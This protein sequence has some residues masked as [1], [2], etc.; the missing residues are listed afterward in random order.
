MFAAGPSGRPDTESQHLPG[1]T[2]VAG[3]PMFAAG[4]VASAE[5]TAGP[6][7]SPEEFNERL[8]QAEAL[9]QKSQFEESQAIY[10]SLVRQP[11]DDAPLATAL[12]ETGW[13]WSLIL[14]DRAEEALAH[15]HRA[16][17]LDPLSAGTM[18]VLA[19]AYLETGDGERALGMALNA[20]QLAPESAEAHA[21]LAEAYLTN[22][23]KQEA[24]KAADK[25]LA[26]DVKSAEA[27]RV[28]G[29]LYVQVDGAPERALGELQI[30]A[31]LQPAL[32][33]RQYEL[34]LIL[35]RVKE[36]G[37]AITVLT[38]ALALYSHGSI[39]AAV[40]EAYYRLDEI[41]RARSYLLQALSNGA[42]DANTYGLLSLTFARQGRC[43]DAK[44]YFDQALAQDAADRPALQARSLCQ[45]TVR[46]SNPAPTELPTAQPTLRGQIAFP[47]WNTKTRQ[48]DVYVVDLGGNATSGGGTMSGGTNRSL[49][50][51]GVHQPAFSPDGR[52]L[53]VN[54]ERPGYMNLSLVRRDGSD[55]QEITENIE[56]GLPNWSPD[57][58]GLVFSSTR[59][60]DRRSRLYVI[61][62]MSFDGERQQGRVL[63]SDQYEVL[64]EYPAWT[65]DGEVVYNGCDYTRTPVQCGLFALPAEPGPQTPTQ[66]TSNP[67]DTAPTVSGEQI[68]FMSNRDGNWEIY[69]VNRDGSGLKRLTDNAANDGLP[70]WSPDGQALAFVSDQGGVWA[71]WAI[72]AD[73][74]GR[75]KLFDLGGGGLTSDW[76]HERI[77]WGP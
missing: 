69:I 38:K 75:R 24:L 16:V 19:R 59:H 57:G 47:V 25:A 29:W 52:W 51:E 76:L 46:G 10:Q 53:A 28:R 72:Q 8:A 42:R 56:D 33:L 54:G 63:N 37:Q 36:Y 31:S 34:G 2:A 12:A 11:P 18:A 22:G 74:S 73:G 50:I 20:I 15:A 3:T 41:E 60:P 68:A 55:L 14:D 39:Y 45:G 35:I 48:Y 71:V 1:Q 7:L 61:D 30:A 65:A 4:S 66:L 70:T 5:V 40:G 49:V 21:V 58:E 32:W 13:A 26:E 77:S 62:K 64:G 67:A 43:D 27:H 17:E 23:Q 6:P 44:L 9:T